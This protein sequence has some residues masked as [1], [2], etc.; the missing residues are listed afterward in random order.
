MK[1]DTKEKILTT[2]YALF[3]LK[4]FESCSMNDIAKEANVN[5]ASLY[6]H[7]PNKEG[8]YAEV[9]KGILES[10]YARVS[11]AVDKE[12]TPHAKLYAF[13]YAFGENF[14]NNHH[15]APLMLRELASNGVNLSMDVK[16]ILLRNMTLLQS[17]LELGKAQGVFKDHPVFVIYLTIVGTMNMYT[18]TSKL[19]KNMHAQSSIDGL[20]LNAKEVANEIMQLLLAGLGTEEVL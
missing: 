7:F 11:S 16:A 20:D 13:I 6:Y 8:L 3:A 19:R 2:A 14:K 4:G 5:K 1:E 10:F 15:M 17:I 18:A 9:I 12:T